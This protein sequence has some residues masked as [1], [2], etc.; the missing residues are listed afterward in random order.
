[1]YVE[2]EEVKENI[3]YLTECTG[4]P[5]SGEAEL[6]GKVYN[7]SDIGHQDSAE[8]TE[9]EAGHPG[10][11]CGKQVAQIDWFVKYRKLIRSDQAEWL[12]QAKLK[13]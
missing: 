7:S 8:C 13:K 11:K 2:R 4:N 5:I 12:D 3:I 1:M 6:L 10:H 9:L